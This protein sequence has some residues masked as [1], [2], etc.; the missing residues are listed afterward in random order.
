VRQFFEVL[1]IKVSGPRSGVNA[2][3][4]FSLQGN[5]CPMVMRSITFCFMPWRR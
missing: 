4:A 3:P 5:R 1:Q 2:R